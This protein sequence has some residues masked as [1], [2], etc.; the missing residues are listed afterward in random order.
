MK[1]RPS[2][3]RKVMAP[4]ACYIEVISSA[5]WLMIA[6][7]TDCTFADPQNF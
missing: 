5:L 2:G 7:A 3:E 4:F 1:W 6:A